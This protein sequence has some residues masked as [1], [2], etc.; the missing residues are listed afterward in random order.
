MNPTPR[1]GSLVIIFAIFFLC[2]APARAQEPQ[3]PAQLRVVIV[4]GEGAVNNV[5]DRVNREPI[6]EVQDENQKPVAGAAVTF[7]LPNQGPGGSFA[8]GTK[9]LTLTTDAQ[10][11]AQAA[12][13]RRNNVA[14]QM[15]IRVSA[16]FQGR[17]ATATITQTNVTGGGSGGLSTTAK[18]LIAVGIA[19]GAAAGAI[20]A[21]HNG[22][23]S[24]TT[25]PAAPPAIVIT[26]GSPSVGAPR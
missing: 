5:K 17:T 26:A 3:A 6:V 7:F 21:T 11:R 8:N 1:Y 16:S 20:V 4:E 25:T 14:G 12:G 2:R 9:T 13:I 24:S 18:V 10:G 23:S 15:Q 19:G 22:G